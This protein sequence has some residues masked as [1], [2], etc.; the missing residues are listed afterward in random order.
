M[1][2]ARRALSC[3]STQSGAG[4]VTVSA[5]APLGLLLLA[6]LLGLA[7]V[8]VATAGGVGVYSHQ[9]FWMYTVQALVL[10]VGAPLLIAFGRPLELLAAVRHRTLHEQLAPTR[11]ED[12][13]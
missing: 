5:G 6:L 11:G 9:L 4:G 2:L 10:L 1:P 12:Q 8:L 13:V 3:S 7:S